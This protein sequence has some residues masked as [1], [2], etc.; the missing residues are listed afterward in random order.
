MF[1]LDLYIQCAQENHLLPLFPQL[2]GSSGNIQDLTTGSLLG[3]VF[4]PQSGPHLHAAS[5]VPSQIYFPRCP[6]EG[7][8]LAPLWVGRGMGREGWGTSSQ[9][10]SRLGS[11]PTD[12]SSVLPSTTTAPLGNP[13]S[14]SDCY[15]PPHLVTLAPGAVKGAA[16]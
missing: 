10:P 6:M 11:P 5:H 16:R 3:Q 4:W 8:A 13:L 2:P 14:I 15:L 1:S 9:H 12:S 7:I